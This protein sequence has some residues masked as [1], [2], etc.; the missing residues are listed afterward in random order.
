[1][2][3]G[4]SDALAFS[5][6][7]AHTLGVFSEPGH[8]GALWEA[9]R[10]T[11]DRGSS[12]KADWRKEGVFF[13][14]HWDR[15]IFFIVSI[16]DFVNWYWTFPHPR[17][18][19]ASTPKRKRTRESRRI[20]G[21]LAQSRRGATK[22]C[23]CVSWNFGSASSSPELLS[24]HICFSPRAEP[25]ADETTDAVTSDAQ[26][27]ASTAPE[28]FACNLRCPARGQPQLPS[29]L[30]GFQPQCC[31]ILTGYPRP[32]SPALHCLSFLICPQ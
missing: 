25:S 16:Y 13:R 1:M 17:K 29:P 15:L 8:P 11:L 23:L 30:P 5:I 18:I 2:I 12:W 32:S 14:M 21:I 7:S 9:G 26:P 22:S 3:S 10:Q 4:S 20:K 24:Q 6:S 31:C 28:P 27:E 19:T